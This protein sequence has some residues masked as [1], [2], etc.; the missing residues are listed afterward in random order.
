MRLCSVDPTCSGTA[1]CV[2][3]CNMFGFSCHHMQCGV[4][5]PSLGFGLV[6]GDEECSETF[7]ELI[8]PI[9]K[10]WHKFD[11]HTQFHRSDLRYVPTH[12]LDHFPSW[13]ELLWSPAHTSRTTCSPWGR[14][15]INCFTF[16][17]QFDLLLPSQ[18]RQAQC[19]LR[20]CRA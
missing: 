6:L 1:L 14:D 16:V 3:E 10:K 18:P 9:I 5:M 19:Q 13:I 11:P 12:S 4:F 15:F 8:Y 17:L 2:F 7:Q 20:K